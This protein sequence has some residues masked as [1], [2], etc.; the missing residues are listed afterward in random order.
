VSFVFEQSGLHHE[1]SR[2]LLEPLQ[3]Q[4]QQQQQ[5]SLVPV[6]GSFSEPVCFFDQHVGRIKALNRT[7]NCGGRCQLPVPQQQQQQQ[8]RRGEVWVKCTARTACCVA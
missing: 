4:Q 8:R 3:Q 6:R 7:V 2:A 5:Q 1:L